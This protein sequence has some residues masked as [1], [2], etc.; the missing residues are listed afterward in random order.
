MTNT[1]RNDKRGRQWREADVQIAHN[2]QEGARNRLWKGQRALNGA[3]L[4]GG[5]R[6]LSRASGHR[7]LLLRD[8]GKVLSGPAILPKG[9]A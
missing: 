3:R 5:S 6:R 8:S 4:S 2:P 7:A 1:Q 9:P